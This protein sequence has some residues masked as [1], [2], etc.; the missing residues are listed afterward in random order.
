MTATHRERETATFRRFRL[1][2]NSMPLGESSGVDVAI[3]YKT[4]GPLVRR[5]ATARAGGLLDKALAVG[6]S[7]TAVE[8]YVCTHFSVAANHVSQLHLARA[9][10]LGSKKAWVADDNA[11]T[12]RT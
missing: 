9:V 7:D 6:D 3:E 12:P 8:R 10:A 1:Y 5:C 4:T 11:R 2:R